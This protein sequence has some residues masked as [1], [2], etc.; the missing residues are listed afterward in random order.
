MEKDE[1]K[2][3]EKRRRAKENRMER[4]SKVEMIRRGHGIGNGENQ[5]SDIKFKDPLS[6]T[7][8]WNAGCE[9]SWSR[10]T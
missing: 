9:V 8:N 6:L 4:G 3:M 7:F 1:K 10:L 2:L 5:L